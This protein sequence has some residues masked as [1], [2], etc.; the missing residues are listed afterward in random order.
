MYGDRSLEDWVK[1]EFEQIKDPRFL[2]FGFDA[3]VQLE[4]VAGFVLFVST[5]DQ[6]ESETTEA[7]I[8]EMARLV[9]DKTQSGLQKA[10]VLQGGPL[11][12]L[13][14]EPNNEVF[15]ATNGEVF[16]YRVPFELKMVNGN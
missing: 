1:S 2:G 6:L 9:L 10:Y 14:F 3:T 7:E 11:Q 5:I 13:Q 4:C 8:E 15:R 16:I 12:P